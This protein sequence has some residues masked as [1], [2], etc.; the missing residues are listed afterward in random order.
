MLV[1]VSQVHFGSQASVKLCYRAD[2]NAARRMKYDVRSAANHAQCAE[3]FELHSHVSSS[4]LHCDAT[5]RLTLVTWG[6]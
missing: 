1:V 3:F 4:A 5:F 6:Q 2:S